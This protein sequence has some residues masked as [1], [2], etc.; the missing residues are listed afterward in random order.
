MFGDFWGFKKGSL[1]EVAAWLPGM[2]VKDD[3][4]RMSGH[5]IVLS[6]SAW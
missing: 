2:V 4:S 3:N 1:V 5:S 6:Y